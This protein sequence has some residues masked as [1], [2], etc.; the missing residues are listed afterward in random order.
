MQFAAGNSMLNTTLADAQQFVK[1]CTAQGKTGGAVFCNPV[2]GAAGENAGGMIPLA[3]FG[4]AGVPTSGPLYLAIQ[5]GGAGD[6]YNIGL[7]LIFMGYGVP[8]NQLF[9]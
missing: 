2:P 1:L 6:Y 3:N 5:F 9:Q 4:E 8:F 7:C